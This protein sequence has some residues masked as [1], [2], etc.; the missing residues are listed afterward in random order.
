[1][2]L[3]FFVFLLGLQTS[4]EAAEEVACGTVIGDVSEVGDALIS[5]SASGCWSASFE[6]P[7]TISALPRCSAEAGYPLGKFGKCGGGDIAMI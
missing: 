1:M 3:L 5:A 6:A 4:V 2:A 7:V